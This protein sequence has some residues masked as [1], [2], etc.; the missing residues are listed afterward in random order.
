MSCPQDRDGVH[1]RFPTKL[2]DDLKYEKA[3]DRRIK[4]IRAREH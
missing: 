1:S 2:D 4:S 3:C